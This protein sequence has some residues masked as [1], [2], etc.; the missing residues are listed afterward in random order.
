MNKAIGPLWKNFSQVGRHPFLSFLIPFCLVLIGRAFLLIWVPPPE[1]LIQD[2]FSYLLAGKTFASFRLTN[3]SPPLW[4][5]FETI[6]ELLQ[7]TYMSKYPPMQ[8][9]LLALGQLIFGTPWMGVLL[10]MALFC[11]LLPWAFRGWIPPGW[12]LAGA[13]IATCKI[14]IMSYWTE[15]YWGGGAAAIGGVLLLGSVARLGR[16]STPE[17]AGIFTVGT[18]ILANSRPFEGALMVVGSGILLFWK[19]F[20]RGRWRITWPS[21]PARA[22]PAVCGVAIPILTVMAFYNFRVTGKA[23]ELPYQTFERQYAV[24]TPF[25]WQQKPSAEPVYRHDFIRREWV[26]WDSLHKTYERKHWVWVHRNNFIGVTRFYFGPI[27]FFGGFIFS[28]GLFCGRKNRTIGGL[29]IF[30][31]VCTATMSDVLP[32]YTAP[33]SALIY[34]A[35]IAAIRGCW[36]SIF[37]KSWMGKG[38]IL[39]TAV[40][41]IALT[42]ISEISP[43]NRFLYYKPHFIEKRHQ[44]L[45]ILNRQAGWQLVFV[46]HGPLHDINEVWTFNEPDIEKSRIIW[47]DSMTPEENQRVLDYYGR[48]RTVWMLNDNDELT[49]G[50]YGHPNDSPILKMLNPP[51][52]PPLKL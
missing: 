40:S 48:M 25:V 29:L 5:H 7:P 37:G 34:L 35:A 2:E 44:V 51:L 13:L 30:Y 42:T 6:H 17:M 16:K 11:G 36:L 32:H 31:Y 47:V 18:G 27:F 21:F 43:E 46:N 10:S 41:F 22:L 26:D 20:G 38:L 39:A 12:A 14:G 28:V 49:L 3:P 4:Q 52:D 33:A 1:P 50:L 19:W 23:T 45:D 15:S 8:G 24:W 9:V